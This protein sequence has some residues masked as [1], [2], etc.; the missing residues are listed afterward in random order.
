MTVNVNNERRVFAISVIDDE[1][2]L[3]EFLGVAVVAELLGN[4]ISEIGE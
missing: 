1:R 3:V 4:E 2:E